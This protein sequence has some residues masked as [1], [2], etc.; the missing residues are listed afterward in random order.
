[1]I[2]QPYHGV[3]GWFMKKNKRRR[4][5]EQLLFDNSSSGYKYSGIFKA[6]KKFK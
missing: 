4:E 1:M 6:Y 5:F 2:D 3:S